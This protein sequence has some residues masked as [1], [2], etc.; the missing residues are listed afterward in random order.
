MK[1]DDIT[2]YWYSERLKK[3]W[4]SSTP[5]LDNEILEKYEAIWEQALSGKLDDWSNDAQGC[6]ALVIVLDQ[7]PLNMFR[8]L[9][10]SFASESKAVEIS[11]K[12]IENKFHQQIPQEQLSFLYMPLMHSENINE[13]DLSVK[14]FQETGMEG[15]IRFSQHHRDI[16][17]KFGRF[18]HRNEI[19]GR[20][21]TAAELE[22]L[23]SEQAFKG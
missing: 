18:P 16:I 22:Y 2:N 6:L 8:G 14:L 21:N 1:P 15:N 23:A 17:K 19:L 13:Q 11:L 20:E 5:D 12:A 7:F 3:H 9:A 10:K 4:F